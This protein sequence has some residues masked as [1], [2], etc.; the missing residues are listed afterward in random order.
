MRAAQINEYGDASRITVNEVQKPSVGEGEVGI[1]VYAASI[2][3]VDSTIRRGFFQ[4]IAPLAFP[5]TIGGDFAGIVSEVGEGV[6]NVSVGGKVYGQSNAAFG[7]SGTMADFVVAPSSQVALA[8]ANTDFI[9]AAS[10][11][12]VG[13]SAIQALFE[14]IKLASGQRILITGGSGGIGSIAIQVA[15]YL[16]AEVTTTATGEGIPLAEE[17]GADTVVDYKSET[18]ELPNDFDAIFDTVGGETLLSILHLVETGGTIVTMGMIDKEAVKDVDATVMMQSTHVTA[19]ALDK[20]RELV[21]GGIVTPQVSQ[22]FTLD[23]VVL[24]FETK[25]NTNVTGKIVIRVR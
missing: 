23:D 22:T 16:G 1:E 5:A 13:V 25:E 7:G 14:H 18:I 2:N 24:A 8:P 11:P 17:L 19:T 15:K 9:Q 6:T 20:L 4:E 10:L 12:L 21:E 3:P